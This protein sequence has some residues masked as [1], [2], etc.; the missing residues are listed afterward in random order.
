MLHSRYCFVSSQQHY[1]EHVVHAQPMVQLVENNQTLSIGQNTFLYLYQ[2]KW[3]W[4]IFPIIDVILLTKW[5][6]LRC[7]R[8]RIII[9]KRDNSFKK[10]VLPWLFNKSSSAWILVTKSFFS[11]VNH[12][13]SCLINIDIVTERI[14]RLGTIKSKNMLAGF[15]WKERND[16]IL[17]FKG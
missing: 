12:T 6:G 4:W 7:N 2:L 8:R 13:C 1:M 17:V 3:W 15:R 16:V 5:S 14:F 9:L 11:S 10:I